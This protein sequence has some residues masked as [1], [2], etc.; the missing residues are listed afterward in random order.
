MENQK[1]L[2]LLN[3]A[4]DSKFVRRTWNILSDQLNASYDVGS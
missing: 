2:S 3:E 1:I 4:S